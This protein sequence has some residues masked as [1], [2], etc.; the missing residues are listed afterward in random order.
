VTW[1][2]HW[3]AVHTGTSNEAG[4]YYAFWSGFGSDLSEA[5][6]LRKHNCH[7]RGCWRIGRHVVDGTPWCDRH[8]GQA[9]ERGAGG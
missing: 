1:L 3:L 7:S 5:A 4:P 9:R 2:L 8:H 6:L